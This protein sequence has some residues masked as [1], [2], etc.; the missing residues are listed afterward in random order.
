MSARS[1][2]VKELTLA[3]AH[4]AQTNKNMATQRRRIARIKCAG[5][6][7]GQA[8][9]LLEAMLDVHARHEGVHNQLLHALLTATTRPAMAY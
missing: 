2:F 8:E 1:H 4:V 5:G 7:T 3:A 9:D 6:N